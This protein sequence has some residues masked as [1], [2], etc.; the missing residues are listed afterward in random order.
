MELLAVIAILGVSIVGE[1][2]LAPRNPV[3]KV[4][5]SIHRLGVVGSRVVRERRGR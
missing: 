2:F 4:R 1:L 5:F 3:Q